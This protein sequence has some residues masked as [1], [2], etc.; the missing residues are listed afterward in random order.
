MSLSWRPLLLGDFDPRI[1]PLL[2]AQKF[3]HDSYEIYLTDMTHLWTETLNRRMICTRAGTLETPIDPTEDAEQMKLLLQKI[4]GGLNLGKD[5]ET[6]MTLGPGASHGDHKLSELNIKLVIEL[7]KPFKPLEWTCT[8]RQARNNK[9]V[10]HFIFPLVCAQNGRMRELESLIELMADK[11]HVIQKLA[12]KLE[13]SGTDL[14]QVFPSAAGKGGRKLTRKAIEERVK[15]LSAFDKQA[16]QQEL[17]STKEK[18]GGD[19]NVGD[20]W[21]AVKG[22]ASEA[23]VL[24][25]GGN[26]HF[27]DPVEGAG[28][29]N[30]FVEEAISIS[31]KKKVDETDQAPADELDNDVEVPGTP[32]PAASQKSSRARSRHTRQIADDDSTDDEDDLDAAYAQRVPD[33]FRASQQPA[34]VPAKKIGVIGTKTQPPETKPPARS[35][36]KPRPSQSQSSHTIVQDDDDTTAGQDDTPP[37]PRKTSPQKSSPRKRTAMPDPA[38]T[39]AKSPKK[40]G[41]GKITGARKKAATPPPASE[42]EPES[43]PPQASQSTPRTEPKLGHLGHRKDDDED[44]RGRTAEKGEEKPR[45]TSEEAKAR[46]KRELEVELERKRNMPQKKKRKF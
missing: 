41:L 12:D 30:C 17:D 39:P 43:S 4:Q 22:L 28:W 20:V 6:S 24:P 14:G 32:P 15:G 40:G 9:I 31:T 38:P 34:K 29:W 23:F 35:P 42:L 2:L 33:S 36:G 13:V 5:A 8:L 37:E 16:W 18:H 26:I 21:K 3:Q 1:P 44:E 10:E 45:E 7:P 25:V 19:D 11:D 46:R 27:P